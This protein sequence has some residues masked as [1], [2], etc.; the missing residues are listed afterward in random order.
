MLFRS[1]TMLYSTVMKMKCQDCGSVFGGDT[2]RWC[3]ECGGLFDLEMN[4]EFPVLRI[5]DRPWDLW[6]YREALPLDLEKGYISLGETCTPLTTVRTEKGPVYLKLD[7]LFPTGSFKDRGAALMINAVN[8]IGINEIVED[9]SGNSGCSVSAYCAK[10]GIKANIYV[11]ASNS[12]GKMNQIRAYGANLVRVEGDREATFQACFEAAKETY[13]ASHV[14]NPYFFQGTKTA[15]FEIVEQLGWRAPE[16]MIVSAGSG[17]ILIGLWIGFGELQRAGVIS[18]MPR[19]VVVQAENCCPLYD[20]WLGREPG[21][22]KATVAEGIAIPKPARWKQIL[23]AVRETKG[24]LVTVTEQQIVDSLRFL[25]NSGYYIEPTSAV[26]FAAFL[27]N[28]FSDLE[29]VILLTGHGLKAADKISE[30]I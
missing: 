3:C 26:P 6:R 21:E 20:L 8:Q 9:S 7:Y 4:S 24:D 15:A 16:Q 22:K 17:S 18:S 11:P 14:W 10:A 12:P 13:Y 23:H 5:K 30:L 29:T 25:V 27:N 28:E 1:D 2:E 19:F